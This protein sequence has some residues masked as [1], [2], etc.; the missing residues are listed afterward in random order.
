MEMKTQT[1]TVICSKIVNNYC[2]CNIKIRYLILQC[3]NE[4]VH[5][6]D[7][8]RGIV[9]RM[10]TLVHRWYTIDGRMRM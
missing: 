8:R 9:S 6:V 3:I 5:F 1:N 4:N 2:Y 7:V 10:F